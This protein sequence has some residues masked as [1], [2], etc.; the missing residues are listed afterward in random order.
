[1]P[2]YFLTW[3]NITSHFRWDDVYSTPFL[4]HV[5]KHL[6]LYVSS[7]TSSTVMLLLVSHVE[8]LTLFILAN[9]S[10][11]YSATHVCHWYV[12]FYICSCYVNI[13]VTLF[14]FWLV[15]SVVQIVLLRHNL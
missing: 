11:Q 15:K 4:W 7:A 6:I 14:H 5:V 3:L 10:S 12:V 2:V 13:L 9:V 1:L 8:C